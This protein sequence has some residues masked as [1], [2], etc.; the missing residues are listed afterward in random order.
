MHVHEAIQSRRSIFKF[1]PEP[2]PRELVER[3]IAFGIWAPCHHVT[4]PWRFTALGEE[5][6]QALAKRYG[7]LQLRKAPPDATPEV[8]AQVQAGGEAK[9]LSKPTMI[10]VSCVQQGTEEQQREDFAACCCAVQNIQLAAWAEGIGMQWSTNPLIR[11]PLTFRLLGIDP[12]QEQ[13]IGFLYA[14]YPAE[15]PTQR[16]RPPGDVFRWTP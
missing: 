16:R 9:F 11:D 13:I 14:G 5:A 8:K 15:T 1:R 4:E 12:D 2:V 3:I 10:V 6:R 7:E